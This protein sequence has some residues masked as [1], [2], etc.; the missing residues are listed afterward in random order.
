MSSVNFVVVNRPTDTYV[1]LAPMIFSRQSLPTLRSFGLVN[2]YFDDYGQPR[3]Y[4]N[5]LFF[6]FHVKDEKTFEQFEDKITSFTSF[7]DYYDVPS[8]VDFKRMYVYRV[9]DV[10]LRDL[11][12]FRH[13]RFDEL[14]EGFK[15]ISLKDINYDDIEFDLTN[16]IYRFHYSLDT[17]KEDL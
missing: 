1:H 5:C 13:R 16:E 4:K 15:K 6:L 10:Y 2:A 11:F 9:N 7:F 12:S 14:T 8:Q 3:K 17:I